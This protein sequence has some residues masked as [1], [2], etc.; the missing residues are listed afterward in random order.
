M[1]DGFGHV[2]SAALDYGPEAISTYQAGRRAAPFVEAA[3]NAGSGAMLGRDVMAMA[4]GGTARTLTGAAVSAGENVLGRIAAGVGLRTAAATGASVATGLAEGAAA[5]AAAGSWVPGV[6]T[7]IG[8]GLGAAASMILPHTP[9][10][11]PIRR[12]PLVGGILAP[13]TSGDAKTQTRME[14]PGYES[15]HTATGSQMAQAAR[16]EY[17]QGKPSYNPGRGFQ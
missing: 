8:A 9:L 2:A 15:P 16:S 13:K 11:A 14:E 5:G 4:R 3:W 10:A 7:L 17:Q 12:I 6:G 1:S